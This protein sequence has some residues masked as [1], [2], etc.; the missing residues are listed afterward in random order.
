M[1][2]LLILLQ[3]I[4]LLMS[5]LTSPCLSNDTFVESE[6]RRK[7][8]RVEP[9]E[10]CFCVIPDGVMDGTGCS[11]GTLPYS[12]HETPDDVSKSVLQNKGALRMM[13]FMLAWMMLVRWWPLICQD[14]GVSYSLI[15]H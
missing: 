1:H 15:L 8:R 2:S 7:V 4:L 14:L 9:M 3:C 10:L 6:L 13:A 11:S 12:G 5:Y